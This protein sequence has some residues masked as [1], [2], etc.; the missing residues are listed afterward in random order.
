MALT[1]TNPTL[2]TSFTSTEVDQNFA[3]VRSKFGSIKNADIASD[4]AISISKLANQYQE[5]WLHFD[6]A[7]VAFTATGVALVIPLPGSDADP[8]WTLTDI[9]WHTTD[10]GDSGNT[11]AFAIRVGRASEAAGSTVAASF[12]T[13]STFGPYALGLSNN[14]SGNG[15]ALEGGSTAITQSS[16]VRLLALDI[17]TS[18]ANSGLLMVSV[19]LRR[20]I[21]A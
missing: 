6:A 5:V 18:S 7:G 17:T 8:A 9:S 3:D 14:V 16:T 19:A 20:Q 4:A 13:T 21:Q 2:S 12:T 11:A 1:L 15:R 10:S